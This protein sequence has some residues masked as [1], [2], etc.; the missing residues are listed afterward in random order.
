[1][2]KIV[3]NETKPSLLFF[4]V[5]ESGSVFSPDVLDITEEDILS[6]FL[7][8]TDLTISYEGVLKCML[9]HAY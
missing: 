6:K 5:Y 8:V 4:S 2:H 3:L 9:L 7:Q 1:M